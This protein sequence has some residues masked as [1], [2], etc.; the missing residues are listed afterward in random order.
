[1]ENKINEDFVC[2]TCFKEFSFKSEYDRHTEKKNPCLTTNQLDK[3]KQKIICDNKYEDKIKELTQQYTKL[4][5]T[6]AKLKTRIVNRYKI[7]KIIKTNKFKNNADVIN[8]NINNNYIYFSTDN[9]QHNDNDE[10][11]EEIK[12][13]FFKTPDID[14]L[15]PIIVIDIII[16]AYKE[17]LSDKIYARLNTDTSIKPEP[18]MI[19][20]APV[21]YFLQEIIKAIYF[22]PKYVNNS[23]WFIN[24]KKLAIGITYLN[25]EK[26]ILSTE[27]TKK[28]I[29]YIIEIIHTVVMPH[30]ESIVLDSLHNKPNIQL[31][32]AYEYMYDEI[33]KFITFDPNA[34]I[35]DIE[36]KERHMD[37][38]DDCTHEKNGGMYR[39]N[40]YR[41]QYILNKQ[42]LHKNT[43]KRIFGI[44][45]ANLKQ[46]LSVKQNKTIKTRLINMLTRYNAKTLKKYKQRILNTSEESLSDDFN[47][48]N[49]PSSNEELNIIYNMMDE[50]DMLEKREKQEKKLK[51]AKPRIRHA[52]SIIY[53]DHFDNDIFSDID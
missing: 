53:E 48:D 42:Q 10:I 46:Y 35:T 40:A 22:N 43:K 37:I 24:D 7:S 44:I 16:N 25:T 50:I 1:M 39:L 17:H 13:N 14:I 47:S 18:H 19:N 20:D 30:I 12:Y 26:M 5:N 23:S 49:Y 45:E 9:N 41:K 32:T 34:K 51:K 28:F 4:Q 52:V 27:N 31:K 11:K 36:Y 6:H 3:I 21:V 2:K 38:M 29:K 15:T 33:E 8:N